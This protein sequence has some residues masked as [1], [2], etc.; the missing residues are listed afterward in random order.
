MNE[1]AREKRSLDAILDD[2]DCRS[3][4]REDVKA[5]GPVTV[6]LTPKYKAKYDRLQEAS[7]RRFIKKLRALVKAAIDRCDTEAAKAG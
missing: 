5:G 4:E 7:N 3:E 6:W 2:F 1:P